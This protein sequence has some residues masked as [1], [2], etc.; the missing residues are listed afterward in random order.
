MA[1]KATVREV[2]LGK[3]DKKNI[4]VLSASGNVYRL[5]EAPLE[6]V[7]ERVKGIQQRRVIN[8]RYWKKVRG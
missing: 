2:A 6:G 8:T 3:Q 4:Y 7:T 1:A 5:I